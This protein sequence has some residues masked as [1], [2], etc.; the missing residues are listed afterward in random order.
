[1]SHEIRKPRETDRIVTYR[2]HGDELWYWYFMDDAGPEGDIAMYPE[3]IRGGH[4][5]ELD[6]YCE[7]QGWAVCRFTLGLGSSYLGLTDGQTHYIDDRK[8]LNVYVE[9][10]TWMMMLQDMQNPGPYVWE[11]TTYASLLHMERDEDSGLWHLKGWLTYG[12]EIFPYP[13]GNVSDYVTSNEQEK[14]SRQR[15]TGADQTTK[16]VTGSERS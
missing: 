3:E 6:C 16:N 12:L 13:R 11:P 9:K 1:M 8:Y 5:T 15:L 4:H 10:N 14:A 7:A 2:D